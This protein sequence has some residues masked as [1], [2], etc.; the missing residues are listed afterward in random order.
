MEEQLQAFFK[1]R[2]FEEDFEFDSDYFENDA[3]VVRTIEM[4]IDNYRTLTFEPDRSN[5]PLHQARI[6]AHTKRVSREMQELRMKKGS[7]E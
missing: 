5:D 1:M 3:R 6:S 7:R 2:D 4:R